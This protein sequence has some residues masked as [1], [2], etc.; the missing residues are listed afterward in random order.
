MRKGT[1]KII[2]ILLMMA[3]ISLIV[4]GCGAGGQDQK[5]TD[6]SKQDEKTKTKDD[7]VIYS[8]LVPETLDQHDSVAV[9]TA[10]YI[11]NLYAN[12]YRLDANGKVIPE[13]AKSSS[14]NDDYTEYTVTLKDGM[15]FSDGSPITAEDVVYTYKRGMNSEV[16]YYEELKKV[17]AKDDKTV[18][19]TLKEPNNEFLND[20]TVEYMCVMSK[21]AIENG[22]D[23]AT[24]PTITSGAYTV[25]QWNKGKSIVMKA[26]PYYFDG[27]PP[28]KTAKVIF[29]LP[30]KNAYEALKN[31]DV[32]YLTSVSVDQV[33]YLQADD[34]V[35]LIA[36]DNF[37]WN[38]MM[39]NEK[40][41]HFADQKV[42]NAIYY[43]LDLNYVIDTA[44]DGRGTP[45]PIP[46]N[47]SIAGYMEECN[48][49][50]F[51]LTKA[52]ECMA[53]SSYPDGFDMTIKVSSDEWEKV[54]KKIGTL[55]SEIGIRV[56]VEREELNQLLS[57]MT[58]YTCEA[59]IIS[60]SMSSG[61]VTHATPLFRPGDSL[62]FAA[63][64]DG[65]IADLLS[66]ASSVDPKEK[67]KLLKEAYQQM[68]EKNLY[69]GLYWPTVYDAKNSKLKQKV[70][71]TSEKF[72]VANMYWE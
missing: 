46:V 45:A 19:I 56:T 40:D 31:G 64:K 11:R 50:E 54:A 27:E 37:A 69:I 1:T 14:V 67:Q 61:T 24:K 33:P 71:V 18:V 34:D 38:F 25:E 65:E 26:N 66:K 4:T 6:A 42:R 47:G 52:K 2:S 3:M 20:L 59:A 60:Y 35:D 16:T 32:D 30:K 51:D 15:K 48:D 29:E 10:I 12:L 68:K 17:E 55:L 62:N 41:A 57:E 44:L 21:D 7:V 58:E 5:T 70:P 22:M 13:L 63:S 43:A 8:K 9:A 28:I 39:L 49:T 23:V 72:I 36:Y 53:E